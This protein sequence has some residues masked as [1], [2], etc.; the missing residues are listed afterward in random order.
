MSSPR[1]TSTRHHKL[2][3][4][5]LR[6]TQLSINQCEY[7]RLDIFDGGRLSVWR[8]KIDGPRYFWVGGQASIGETLGIRAVTIETRADKK[9]PAS[10]ARRVS[11]M[12]LKSYWLNATPLKAATPTEFDVA[13]G[14]RSP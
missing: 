1:A 9:N 14:V 11:E 5:S 13:T 7:S 8:V 3:G 12:E 6:Q 4:Q 10:N 2:L